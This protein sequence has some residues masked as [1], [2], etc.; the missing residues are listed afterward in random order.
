MKVHVIAPHKKSRHQQPF[1]VLFS[2]DWLPTVHEVLH[3]D[4]HEVWH[5][6][7]PSFLGLSSLVSLIGTICFINTSAL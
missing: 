3:A 7:Q 1:S 2:Q 6:P 4:W 5:S